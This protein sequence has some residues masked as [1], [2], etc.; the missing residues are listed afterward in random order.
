MKEPDLEKT[1]ILIY[2]NKKDKAVMSVA[3]IV[4]EMKLN[5]MKKKHWF[6]VGSNATTGEGIMEGLE[7]VVSTYSEMNE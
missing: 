6:I 5:E 4:E 1:A 3:E 7:W 2:A